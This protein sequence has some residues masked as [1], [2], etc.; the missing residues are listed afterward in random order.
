MKRRSVF[1]ALIV[2]SLAGVTWAQEVLPPRVVKVTGTS[3]VKVAP[4]RAL[5][6]VGVQKQNGSAAVAQKAARDAAQ[7]ILA[8][9]KTNGIDDKDVQT[10]YL[11]LEPQY[12]YKTN[13]VTFFLAEQTLTVTVRD[14]PKLDHILDILIKAGTNRVGS[15]QYETSEL[16]KYRDQARELAIKAAREKAEALAKALG[17]S[18]GK[19]YMIEEQRQQ[20]SYG[21]FAANTTFENDKARSGPST[22]PGQN[23]I[24]A[25]VTV[26]F[27]LQ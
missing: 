14:L 15:I 10:T 25:S 16:R 9:L 26:W 5:I 13:R 18:I 8:A 19:A 7:S 20:E 2:I 22:A 17:Q 27:D 21:Y 1:L 12:D 24:T 4:D 11:S 6:E 3:D 23:A